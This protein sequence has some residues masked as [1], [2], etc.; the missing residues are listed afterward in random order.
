MQGRNEVGSLADARY[1]SLTTFRRDGST[2]S[3][4]VWTASDDG[5]RLLVWTGAQ[6]WKAKRLRRDPRVLVAASDARGREIGSRI[7]GVARIHDDAELARRVLR[8]KYGWQWR[9]L[10]FWGRVGRRLGRRPPRP[11]IAIEIVDGPAAQPRTA[12]AAASPSTRAWASP[13]A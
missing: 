12:S 11:S 9:A 3:T 1:I 2:A 6:T 8:G 10:E 7:A 13:L 5:R 4:P